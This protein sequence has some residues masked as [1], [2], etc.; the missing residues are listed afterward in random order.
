MDF[1]VPV[2]LSSGGYK[3]RPSPAGRAPVATVV[4]NIC[5]NCEKACRETDEI[6][7]DASSER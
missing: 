1:G 7:E 6:L 4:A 2:G 3:A 5:A